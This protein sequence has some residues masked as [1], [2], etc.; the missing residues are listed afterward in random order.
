MV[1]GR[2]VLDGTA[3]EIR[4]RGNLNQIYFALADNR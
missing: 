3:A 1:K 4:G 2:I